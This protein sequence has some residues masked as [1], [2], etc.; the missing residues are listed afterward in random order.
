MRLILIPFILM[1]L[2]SHSQALETYRWKNRILLL[3]EKQEELSRS[4]KQIGMFSKVKKEM[5]E[6]QL[7]LLIYDGRNLRDENTEVLAS[8]RVGLLKEDFEGVLLIGKDGG[9]KFESDF[10][11]TPE[12]ILGLIDS[13]PMRRAEMRRKND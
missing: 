6:R 1:P 5:E 4:R 2:L 9:V 13:M 7:L 10:F 8:T 11:V 12:A 3:C